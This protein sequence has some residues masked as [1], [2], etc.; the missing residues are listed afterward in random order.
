MGPSFEIPERV[1]N[2]AITENI[3][4]GRAFE[5]LGLHEQSQLK[6]I[7]AVDY[8]TKSRMNRKELVRLALLMAFQEFDN[9]D[10]FE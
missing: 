6:I 5:K 9:K 4:V 8:L 10:L 1:S 7:G 2:I 3:E